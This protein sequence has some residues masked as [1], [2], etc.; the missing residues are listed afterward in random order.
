MAAFRLP[1]GRCARPILH[2]ACAL[3]WCGLLLPAHMAEAQDAYPT[4]PVRLISP[5]PPGGPNDLIA[6]AVADRLGEILRQSVIVENRSGAGGTIGTAAAAKAEPDG[7]TLVIVSG[8]SVI[9]PFLYQNLPYDLVRDFAPIGM[10]GSSSFILLAHHSVPVKNL[11][12]LIAFAKKHPGELTYS[13]PGVGT[14]GHVAGELLNRAAGIKLTHV[15]YRGTALAF[16]D[17]LTGRVLLTFQGGDGTAALKPVQDGQ[18]RAIAATGPRRSPRWPELPTMIEAG[19]PDFEVTTWYGFMA[20][21]GTPRP[22]ID[23]LSAALKQVTT[24][25]KFGEQLE[26]MGMAPATSTPDEFG[27]LVRD[28]AERVGPIAKAAGMKPK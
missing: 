1:G 23:R 7:Y 3:L 13:T 15:P 18:M 4:R 19:I 22:I 16:Q 5:Y 2:L 10:V 21:A 25:A 6:R 9:A 17:F 8:A 11:D 27:K 14:P 26:R 24:D 28:E 12:E 20:P